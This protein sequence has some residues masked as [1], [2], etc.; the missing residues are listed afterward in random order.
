MAL[1]DDIVVPFHIGDGSVR[2]RIIRLGASIDAILMS[3]GYDNIRTR[4]LGELAMAAAMMGAG[5]KFDGR[6]ILQLQSAGPVRLLVA[7]YSTDGA[8]RATAG[9][10]SA[11]VS[12]PLSEALGAGA[13]TATIDQGPDMER[14]QGATPI[15]GETI[16]EAV[17]AYFAQSEQ[18]ATAA[19]LAVGAVQ[20]PGAP[21]RYR[22]GG[23][24]IQKMPDEGGRA[25]SRLGDDLWSRASIF[26]ATA[27]DDELLDPLLSHER[28]LYRLF[29]E[30]GVVVDPP[31]SVFAKC[32]C[33]AARIESV[34]MGYGADDLAEM[35]EDGVISATCE[36]CRTRYAFDAAGKAIGDDER[37]E[38]RG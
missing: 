27:A 32:R 6:L 11:P 4:L 23:I 21:M 30:D 14:Y 2:G 36:F 20:N 24:L 10:G 15:E 12:S 38:I 9:D 34:L 8:L 29:G 37:Q 13:F 19:R 18:I 5:L 16:A 3:H 17:A 1:V 31:R 28:L 25:P 26:L 35:A 33:S 7:D 22:A